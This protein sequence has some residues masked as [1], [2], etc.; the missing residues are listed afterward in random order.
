VVVVDVT[1]VVEVVLV[2]VVVV[3]GA[4]VVVVVVGGNVVDVDVDGGRVVAGATVVVVVVVGVFV[5]TISRMRPGV[6]VGEVV[7]WPFCWASCCA[8]R[9]Y[10]A[11]IVA[12]ES[13]PGR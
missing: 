7:F 9:P 11:A 5:R 8:V 13:E 6:S 3:V 2:V 12:H 4:T 1:V 10:R